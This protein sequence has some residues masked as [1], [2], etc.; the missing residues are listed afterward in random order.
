MK[1]IS[2]PERG[3]TVLLAALFLFSVAFLGACEPTPPIPELEDE[4]HA[5]FDRHGI[6]PDPAE[7]STDPVLPVYREV[8]EFVDFIEEARQEELRVVDQDFV[9]E[10]MNHLHSA[11][12]D[13]TV[14]R[15]L[16]AVPEQPGLPDPQPSIVPPDDPQQEVVPPREAMEQEL[17]LLRSH[18][19][20]MEP[21]TAE[22]EFSTEL[23]TAAR[24]A[25]E[26]L[27]IIQEEDFPRFTVEVREVAATVDA[28][29]PA[30]SLDE[31]RREVMDYLT[32]TADVLDAM[33]RQ[34]R[35]EIR[36]RT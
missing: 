4:E 8:T 12:A 2:N 17:Q 20:R 9:V 5:G 18:I 34:I 13:M 24:A 29:D 22:S 15:Y 14:E 26:L 21:T 36:G 11:L 23:K 30:M 19:D 10:A 6:S 31:Q 25:T 1:A 32:T 7:S 33:E 35:T 16:E 28:L 27:M 3:G